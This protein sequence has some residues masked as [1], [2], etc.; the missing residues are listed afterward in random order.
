MLRPWPTLLV[1]VALCL[2]GCSHRVLTIFFTGVPAPG[3]QSAVIE[4][5]AQSLPDEIVDPRAIPEQADFT[6]GP[7]VN[8]Q[9]SDCHISGTGRTFNAISAQG[10]SMSRLAHA[11]EELC[12][13]C[14]NSDR[15]AP[16]TGKAWIHAPVVNGNCLACHNPHKSP[17]QFMLKSADNFSLCT[18]CHD[19]TDLG[20]TTEHD[21]AAQ[22]D[23]VAC[24]SPHNGPGPMLLR[25]DTQT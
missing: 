11:R 6:H 12:L 17:R 10:P 18:Q 14:H 2:G 4:S 7:W 23:C 20:T 15:F 16:R 9:C 3:Q 25:R 22:K 19:V 21:F 24:H 13:Q 1:I 5:T 8:Q